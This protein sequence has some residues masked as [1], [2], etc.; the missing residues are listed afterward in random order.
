MVGL[1][2]VVLAAT[3]GGEGVPHPI[4]PAV[5][6]IHSSNGFGSG[7][8]VRRDGLILTNAHVVKGDDT[9]E[10][11]LFDGLR[12]RG[13]VLERATS[14]A[15]LALVKMDAQTESVLPLTG[16]T[17]AEPGSWVAAIGYG[18]F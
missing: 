11:E 9:V 15:D 13:T 16:Y 6:H 4:A 14:N 18:G 5:V 12:L 3:P 2:L 17:D 10:V 1:V 7:F 8:F